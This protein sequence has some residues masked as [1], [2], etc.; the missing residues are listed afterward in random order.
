[1]KKRRMNLGTCVVWQKL[2][3]LQILKFDPSDSV[4]RGTKHNHKILMDIP[5]QNGPIFGLARDESPEPW[6][7]VPGEQDKQLAKW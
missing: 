5:N 7:I 2:K 6:T 4:W 3:V 1:M